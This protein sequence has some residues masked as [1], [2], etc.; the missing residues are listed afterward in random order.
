M[1]EVE[2]KIRGVAKPVLASLVSLILMAAAAEL[3][4]SL[5]VLREKYVRHFRYRVAPSTLRVEDAQRFF[6]PAV[7]AR[8]RGFD[9]DL[10]WDR[11]PVARNYEPTKGYVAQS[12]GDSFTEGEVPPDDTW[13]ARFEKLTGQA[14]LN[15]G[16]GGY[17]VDQAVLKFEKYGHQHRTRL[18]ILGLYN[19][20]YRRALS[21]YSLYYFR[22]DNFRFAFK[23]MFVQRD[24]RFELI[25][26]PCAD[27]ACLVQLLSNREHEVWRRLAQD[28]YWYRANESLPTPGFPNTVAFAR[29]AGKI[30]R[31]RRESRGAENYFFVNTAS[32]DLT[33][34][35]VERF[36]Q[37]SRQRGMQPVCVMLYS[38]KDLRLIKTGTRFDDE[39][40]RRIAAKGI[41]CVDTA[42]YMLEHARGENDLAV[43]STH[44]GHL[45]GR[46]NLLVAGALAR[47]LAAMAFLTD[48]PAGE[49][50]KL[51]TPPT[52]PR[53]R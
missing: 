26:P 36:A 45:N 14:I 28:D 2:T 42:P 29:V 12:Y 33:E 16:V 20:M 32:L 48:E 51:D 35:L 15:L 25:R 24:G 22:N 1:P 6:A 13:Q 44:D 5:P 41:P 43:L 9:A 34:Y 10:G 47:G 49:K 7:K 40:T 27:A 31:E 39:L 38:V 8:V 50:A 18:A 4:L 3:V 23:P 17:G 53:R 21:H 19:Q 46:G 37:A 30:L 52:P 11:T